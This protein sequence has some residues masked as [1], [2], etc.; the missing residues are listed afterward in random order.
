[1]LFGCPLYSV[2]PAANT[3]ENMRLFYPILEVI[4]R[5]SDPPDTEIANYNRPTKIN[6]VVNSAIAVSL[7]KT[8]INVWSF[9]KPEML[10]CVLHVN[11]AITCRPFKN[12]KFYGVFCK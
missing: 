7:E 11:T 2:T 6:R 8:V 12:K 1:M 10:W 5:P 4:F 3:M 9:E